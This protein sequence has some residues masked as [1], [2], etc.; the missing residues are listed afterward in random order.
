MVGEMSGTPIFEQLRQDYAEAGKAWPED[1][2]QPP[3]GSVLDG[4]ARSTAGDVLVHELD[5][6]VPLALAELTCPAE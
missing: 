3:V 1:A 2:T 5:E 4:P 6:P